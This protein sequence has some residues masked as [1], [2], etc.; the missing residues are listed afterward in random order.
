MRLVKELK[1]SSFVKAKDDGSLGDSHLKAA[2]SAC[3]ELVESSVPGQITCFRCSVLP[4][5]KSGKDLLKNKTCWC[6]EWNMAPSKGFGPL[7]DWLTASR[8]TGLSHDG[9]SRCPM[10]LS[11]SKYYLSLVF[12]RRFILFV[13][14]SVLQLPWSLCR[15]LWL[16]FG[17]ISQKMTSQ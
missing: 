7:T 2:A 10:H 12:Q 15:I 1:K 16:F 8:S 3:Y 6:L 11:V 17:T 4:L 9:T 5:V 14:L 13:V